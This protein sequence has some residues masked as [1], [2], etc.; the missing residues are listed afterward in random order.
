M[1]SGALH[2]RYLVAENW[3]RGGC[4]SVVRP[5]AITVELYSLRHCARLAG[6][7]VAGPPDLDSGKRAPE[8]QARMTAA[9]LFE[10]EPNILL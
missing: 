2:G 10:K 9:R 3:L 4:W 1:P 5:T 6:G 8:R 7:L